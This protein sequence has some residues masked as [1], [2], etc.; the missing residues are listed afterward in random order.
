MAANTL[1]IYSKAGDVQ[2]SAA[3]ITSANTA[4][5]GTGT[6]TAVFTAGVDGGRVEKLV[7]QPLG[8]NVATVA[9]IFVNNGQ[10]NATPA[11]NA[12]FKD[13]TLPASTLSENASMPAVEVPL[14]LAL[15]SG[16][17]LLVTLG[18]AIA[19]GV[20]VTVVGGKY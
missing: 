14:N 3:A 19:A 7:F 13:V 20:M 6:V 18:T 16:Y 11:N 17:R 10:S 4:K 9:R 5:D 2:W 8:T 12:Y 15:P 1:P